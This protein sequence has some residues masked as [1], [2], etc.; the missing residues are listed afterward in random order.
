M[1]I[2]IPSD[3]FVLLSSIHPLPIHSTAKQLTESAVGVHEPPENDF[4][5]FLSMLMLKTQSPVLSD[6]HDV[7]DDNRIIFDDNVVH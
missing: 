7:V 2:F 5:R 4:E 6:R 1:S 3:E